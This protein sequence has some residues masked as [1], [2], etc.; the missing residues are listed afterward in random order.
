MHALEMANL[1]NLRRRDAFI[2]GVIV[3]IICTESMTQC[4]IREHS[5]GYPPPI[6]RAKPR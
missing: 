4:C 3:V 1:L 6:T 2:L 5:Q